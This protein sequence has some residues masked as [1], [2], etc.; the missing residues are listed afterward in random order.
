MPLSN[1]LVIA[2]VI[3]FAL[4]VIKSDGKSEVAWGGLAISVAEG[5][6]RF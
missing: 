3:L 6:T 4:A 1:I 2:A 5:L